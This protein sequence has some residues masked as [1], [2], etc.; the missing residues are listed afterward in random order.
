M[1]NLAFDCK[2]YA[3]AL[4]YLEGYLKEVVERRISSSQETFQREIPLF[5]KIFTSLDEIDFVDGCNTKRVNE[6]SLEE[7]V[8]IHEVAGEIQEALNFCGKLIQ[9]N[10]INFEYRSKYM[11]I[12]LNDVDQVDNVYHYGRDLMNQNDNWKKETTPYVVEAAWKLGFWDQID[13]SLKDYNIAC[14]SNIG[15]G[16][17]I[18]LSTIKKNKFEDFEAKL[19]LIRE[20]QID[21][22]TAA[23]M[24][25]K[26]YMRGHQAIIG[27]HI[28]NDIQVAIKYLYDLQNDDVDMEDDEVREIPSPK[29]RF[30]Q[31]VKIWDERLSLVRK[32]FTSQEPILSLHRAMMSIIKHNFPNLEPLV[33]KEIFKTWIKSLRLSRKVGCVQRAYT[34]WPNVEI[35]FNNLDTTLL[36]SN[37]IAM[38]FSEQAKVLWRH[39]QKENAIKTLKDVINR[40]FNDVKFYCFSK[41]KIEKKDSLIKALESNFSSS[42]QSIS[43]NGSD[44]TSSSN[45]QIDVTPISYI[46]LIQSN[47][48]AFAKL[49]LL[50]S[51]YI[52]EESLYSTS[53][54]AS[55][56]QCVTISYENWEKG[57]YY[58]GM[59]YNKILENEENKIKCDR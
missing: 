55:M 3:R 7:M 10:P 25:V 56:Y 39:G 34:C 53:N 38:K 33:N 44:S 46:E 21:P 43:L 5:L 45:S 57:Y 15:V 32:A 11:S 8:L 12:L 2:A 1:A 40:Y 58:L 37:E 27:L 17:G 20:Q 31:V 19:N 42:D 26:G 36:D 35:S 28:L 30:L 4:R 52:D 54:I 22:L 16:I 24:E 59:Y 13:D 6:P 29:D 51:K 18:L 47:K 41:L 14:Q 48:I 23:A 9:T 50:L 49:Q